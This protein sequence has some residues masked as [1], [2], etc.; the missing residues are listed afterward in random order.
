M[1]QLMKN[2]QTIIKIHPKISNIIALGALSNSS[3]STIPIISDT[4]LYSEE[5]VTWVNDQINYYMNTLLFRN[6]DKRIGAPY[7]SSINNLMSESALGTYYI[8]DDTYS[9]AN[10]INNSYI[11]D[12][13]SKVY[14]ND[15][16]SFYC[17]GA[18]IIKDGETIRDN[19]NFYAFLSGDIHFEI[20]S[21]DEWSRLYK[22]W[23]ALKSQYDL[24]SNTDWTDETT[25]TT[26]ESN[27][28]T[29]TYGK[30][31]KTS[32]NGNNSNSNTETRDLVNKDIGTDRTQE[33][34]KTEYGS[35]DDN[36]NTT[37]MDYNDY[38]ETETGSGSNKQK[39]TDTGTNKTTYGK[40]VSSTNDQNNDIYG[41]NSSKAVGDSVRE[42]KGNETN[43]GSDSVE[44][45]SNETIDST[46]S[47]NN[48]KIITGTTTNKVIEANKKGGS[49]L[50]TNNITLDHNLSSTNSGT[51][52]NS[53][54]ATVSSAHD[55]IYSGDDANTGTRNIKF[56][57]TEHKK[58]NI[59]VTTSQ[60]LIE[61]ELKLREHDLASVIFKAI[62]DKLFLK[63][64]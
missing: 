31:V 16:D 57:H 39:T 23:T 55:E 9:S 7:F 48:S 53:G 22:S 20:L 29:L 26:D 60:Q 41:Y 25:D 58:G 19:N 28:N 51:V 42:S 56:I 40:K 59:G 13:I 44:N 2:Y 61:S 47:S 33:T 24:L 37:T 10:N 12:D 52:T 46:N 18:K 15:I 35:T 4:D 45:S 54:S 27:A 5:F 36:T 32:D 14:Y 30:K 6:L 38:K 64:Y 62:E 3:I 63:V 50:V 43:S 17:N 34:N 49:D 1:I 21:P 11:I 8:T